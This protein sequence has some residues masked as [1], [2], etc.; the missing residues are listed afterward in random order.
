MKKRNFS[1]KLNLNKQTVTSLENRL[2]EQVKGGDLQSGLPNEC[3][4]ITRCQTVCP[5]GPWC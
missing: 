2:M 3:N 1:K 4:T 5:D